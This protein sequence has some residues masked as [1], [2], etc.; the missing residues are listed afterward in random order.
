MPAPAPVP[1]ASVGN[2]SSVANIFKTLHS[3]PSTTHTHTP[4]HTK[5]SSLCFNEMCV[6]CVRSRNASGRGWGK[7]YSAGGEAAC[8]RCCCH[9]KNCAQKYATLCRAF[10]INTIYVP[11][12]RRVFIFY[13][14]LFF[15]FFAPALF[16]LTQ[17]LCNGKNFWLKQFKKC[18][19]S[20][21]VILVIICKFQLNWHLLLI[22]ECKTFK[23][24]CLS[25]LTVSSYGK[26][27]RTSINLC[28]G[29]NHFGGEEKNQTIAVG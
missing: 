1:D 18:F 23:W 2:G 4:T 5:M 26:G 10:Q 22:S 11:R 29:I 6:A 12:L 3:R 15:Y 13:S 21:F 17:H 14:L 19:A 7:Q 16:I 24:H 9:L 8:Q 20:N 28:S 27:K 25:A